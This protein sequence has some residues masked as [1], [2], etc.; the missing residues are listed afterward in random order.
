[1]DDKDPR[2]A[3]PATH[4]KVAELI[5]NVTHQLDGSIK[6]WPSNI[7]DGVY[8]ALERIVKRTDMPYEIV[9]AY[10]DTDV[11]SGPFIRVIAAALKPKVH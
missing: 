10:S 9:A 11:D 1:M 6:D 5:A 8:A 4:V 2:A 3:V 7:Q